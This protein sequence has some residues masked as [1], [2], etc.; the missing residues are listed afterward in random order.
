MLVIPV[1]STGDTKKIPYTTL[2]LIIINCLVFFFIQSGDSRKHFEAYSFYEDSGLARIELTAYLEYL[3]RSGGQVSSVLNN[4]AERQ[5]Y[6]WEMF[7][8][9]TFQ[10][11]LRNEEIISPGSPEYEKWRTA[12]TEFDTLLNKTV[13]NRYGYS[14]VKKNYIGLLTHMFL[15]GGVM[16]LVGN[17]VFLWLVGGLLELAIGPVFFLGGYLVTGVCACLLFSFVYPLEMGPLIG[18]SGA[19][20]GL[21]G[22]YAV[23]FWRKKIRIFYSLGFYFDYA[24]I[25]A[26]ALLP[27]WIGNEFFQLFMRPDSNVAYMAHIGGLVSGSALAGLHLAL[28]GNKTDELFREEEEKGLLEQL[29]D[30]GQN[31][32]ASLDIEGARK[33]MEEVLKLKPGHP[34]AIRNL[35]TIDKTEPTS[36]AFHQSASRLLSYLLRGNED[37]FLAVFEEYTKLSGKPRLNTPI[38][39]RLV[40]VYLDKGLLK[41]ASAYLVL[42]IKKAPEEPLIPPGLMRLARSYHKT[43]RKEAARK[44]LD[45]LARQFGKSQE[46]IEAGKI[47]A[48]M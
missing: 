34:L 16:H 27:F 6:S 26:L 39:K 15:H 19:I 46:G 2:G 18:A 43:G 35:Y 3:G 12:R 29:L 23:F 30:S 21:M 14:P 33:D 47:L 4:P 45:V 20:A 28:C 37:D 10:N 11:K 5:Q 31:K 24:R 25:P 17:M 32:L 8:D 7:N 42:L 22:A 13:I 38:I 41:E 48:R 9:S 36:E 1:T 40:S 44:C